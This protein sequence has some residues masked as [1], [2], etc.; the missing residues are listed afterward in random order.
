[1]L[2]RTDYTTFE[3]AVNEKNAGKHKEV[4]YFS[5]EGRF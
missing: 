1:M 2:I 4:A 5:G 3:G